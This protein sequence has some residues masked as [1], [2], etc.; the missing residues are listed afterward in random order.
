[1]PIIKG[2]MALTLA[3]AA[4]GAWAQS[5]GDPDALDQVDVISTTPFEGSEVDA[6]RYPANVQSSTAADIERSESVNMVEFLNT[7]LGSV[8]VNDAVNNPFQPDLKYRGYVAS[9]LLGLPQGLSVYQDGV[10]VNE[11]FGDTVNFDLIPQAAIADIDLLPGSNPLFGLNTLGG[12]LNI[13]TKSGFSHPGLQAQAYGG[14]F[15]RYGGHV[16]LGGNSG[17]LGWLFLV[18]GME[19]DGWRDFSDSEVLQLFSKFSH[20]GEHGE[21]HFSVTAADN[22][23]RGNGAV[24]QR[25]AEERGRDQ[26]FTY[27]DETSPQLMMFN[28][29]GVRD[30]S[31]RTSLAWGGYYRQS[32]VDT[33]NGD[34]SE[35]D[36]CE[37][38][39]GAGD[40]NAANLCEEPEEPDTMA[41]VVEQPNGDP[42]PAGPATL[43]GTQNTSSTRQ[44]GYGVNLQLRT[45]GLIGG[46]LT[47]GLTYDAGDSDFASQQEVARLTTERGT[48]GSGFFVGESFTRVNVENDNIGAFFMH[49]APLT[50]D[51]EWTLGGRF[52]RTNITL[53]D[54]TPAFATEPGN[55][56]DG[57]HHFSRLNMTTG[58]AWAVSRQ[59]TF[60][61]SV[62]QSSRAPSPLELTCANPDAPCRLPNGFVDDP[63]LEQVV[64]TTVEIGA[65][66]GTR[67]LGWRSAVFHAV[68]EDDIIFISAGNRFEGFFDNVGDTRRQGVELG[69]DWQAMPRLRLTADYTFV[70]AEFR[71][72]FRV[73][74]PNHP[75]R[76]P[77][78]DN[79]G[80]TRAAESAQ[81]V[82]S[83]DRLPL[84]PE[85][86][87]KL[88]A[89][90]N[91][92]E[93]LRL[94]LDVVG[95]SDQIFRGDESNTDSE[96]IGGYAIVNLHGEL[97]VTNA[98]SLFARV[99]NV[100]DTDYE[101]F[102]VYGESDEV[103]AGPQ[104]EDAFRFI[105]PGAPRGIWGGIRVAL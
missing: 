39:L 87:F 66:G 12:A 68:N 70:Q 50:P 103:L 1:M 56:L 5:S 79:P 31:D 100:F 34:G 51:L 7:E 97:A 65:R 75:N 78:P 99:N 44:D 11:P 72:S 94:G 64:A 29:R 13:K 45:P 60:F 15:G 82:N 62:G 41:E 86:I 25:L 19:E 55:S 88:G 96:Q 69:L 53:N 81:Q 37:E 40:P 83:G 77:D 2:K 49:R 48:V 85:H 47:T 63:P 6:D 76:E 80:E 21:T 30:L 18:Q 89:D 92:T 101:T 36:E 84:V 24:P 35:F 57:D 102:G 26:I 67:H 20:I 46:E 52:N 10:R 58:M 91:A 73:N 42:I 22:R 3:L 16:S 9:P 105:G 4:T 95:N 8:H 14:D 93:Q 74:S 54:Q 17:N 71:D 61:S 27:P 104:F 28:L 32:D 38:F 33:F 59:L 23:L 98:V 90:W 43:G